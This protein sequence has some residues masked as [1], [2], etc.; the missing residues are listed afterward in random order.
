MKSNVTVWQSIKAF[1][2]NSIL[3]RNFIFILVLIILPLT[4]IVSINYKDY[5][6]E[7][8]RQM[9]VNNAN[10]LEKCVV[11]GDN[12]FRESLDLMDKFSG[13]EEVKNLLEKGESDKNYDEYCSK[14]MEQIYQY[15][16]NKSYVDQIYIYSN[17][18]HAVL[19]YDGIHTLDSVRDK[20][21]DLYS[22]LSLKDTCIFTSKTDG[23]VLICKPMF[24]DIGNPTGIVVINVNMQT[25]G[26]ML[27]E[28]KITLDR[29]LLI[30]DYSGK[31]IFGKE[32]LQNASEEKIINRIIR[33]ESGETTFV[34]YNNTEVLSVMESEFKVYRF[35]LITDKT[36]FEEEANRLNNYLSITLI[37]LIT[38]S[39]VATWLITILT[40][41]PV[42]KIIN[43]IQKP[44]ENKKNKEIPRKQ[45][46]LLYII[47]NILNNI[48]SKD[49]MTEELQQR[50]QLLN[51]AQ[52]RVLQFQ[53]NPHFLANTLEIIKW[54]SV[55][56][57]G[58]GNNTSKMLT[59]L[60][61]L[62]RDALQDD[63]ILV[64]LEEEIRY[65]K[66]YMEILNFRYAE[67]IQFFLDVDEKAFQYHVIKMS[68][69][70]LLENAV[71]HGLT[72]KQYYGEISVSIQVVGTSLKI[73]V[74]DDGESLPKS[75]MENINASL[76]D[77][78]SDNVHVG[79]Q[80]V[81]TRVKLICG[82]NY[83]VQLYP[84]V[85]KGGVIAELVLPLF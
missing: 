74:A 6:K 45:D 7:I 51:T 41:G 4:V 78:K 50:I 39:L 21:Y 31:V 84:N 20:W 59:K 56:E 17:Y 72:S 40:Y 80:N 75:K 37:V 53:M 73:R 69:Q 23:I 64:P 26:K 62:Y 38:L 57:Y 49:R 71:T 81:N 33:M 61:K 25:L 32:L 67:R 14:L 65:L 79:L 13:S 54:S 76:K 46:E 42:K 82:K 8:Q 85:E 70:P 83:G 58:L 30:V 11:L 35:V 15:C 5:T 22:T 2:L 44:Y 77:Q 47:S 66:N 12:L 48:E 27:E 28:D 60:A 52:A 63:V 1:K 10:V 36:Y 19:S 34:P 24:N 29:K 43:S 68:I 3:L 16:Q 18:D 55:E 9:R